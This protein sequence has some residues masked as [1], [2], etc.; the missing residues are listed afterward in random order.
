MDT[1]GYGCLQHQKVRMYTHHGVKLRPKNQMYEIIDQKKEH[2][3]TN[4]CLL[5]PNVLLTDN[6]YAFR[7]GLGDT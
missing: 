1:T 5:H 4:L 3:V 6:F 7:L 2:L